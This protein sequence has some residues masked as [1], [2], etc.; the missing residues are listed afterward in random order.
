MARVDCALASDFRRLFRRPVGGVRA[1]T[2]TPTSTTAALP[3]KNPI[4]YPTFARVLTKELTQM[5][6]REHSDCFIGAR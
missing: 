1:G 6:D 3:R 5:D 4:G 2:K